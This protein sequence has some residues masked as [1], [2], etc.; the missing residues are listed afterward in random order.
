MK[1][2]SIVARLL[3]EEH[4]TR[5]EAVTL[6]AYDEPVMVHTPFFEHSPPFHLPSLDFDKAAKCPCRTENGGSGVCGCTI[7]TPTVNA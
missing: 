1:K 2:T 6:L 3:M 4:I 7:Y 5:E